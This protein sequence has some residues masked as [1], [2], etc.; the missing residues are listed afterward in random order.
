M[1]RTLLI[2]VLTCATMFLVAGCG[3]SD[4][5][6]GG[7]DE[8][9]TPAAGA[10][11]TPGGGSGP[12]E[13]GVEPTEAAADDETA[14]ELPP[15]A[16]ALL[17]LT[18]VQQLAPMASAG[19]PTADEGAIASVGCV[20]EWTDP[21][22]AI[23]GTGTLEVHVANLPPGVSQETVRQSLTVEVADAGENGRE[24]TGI[25][26]YAI[27]TSPIGG[28]AEVQALVDGLLVTVELGGYVDGVVAREKQDDVIPLAEI[29]AERV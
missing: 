6:D 27:L 17:T 28:S 7:S 26:Q 14:V 12:T 4:Y 18:E 19:T 15:D 21:Q 8:S 22:D 3:G 23:G 9:D 2:G 5:G 16:C 25:G 29:V 11:T 13:E 24:L 20:W 1:I 10:G